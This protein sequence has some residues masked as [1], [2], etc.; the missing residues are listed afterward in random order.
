MNRIHE[1]FTQS[2]QILLMTSKHAQ[3]PAIN[4][5]ELGLQCAMFHFG[6]DAARLIVTDPLEVPGRPL[7]PKSV[8][9]V[10]P[11]KRIQIKCIQYR[12]L[13]SPAGSDETF[14]QDFF[15]PVDGY[16]FL[17]GWKIVHES[18]DGKPMFEVYSMNELMKT[19]VFN[20][21]EFGTQF[22]N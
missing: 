3:I 7:S 5:T 9:G 19:D 2:Y 20:D 1:L 12:I 14:V 6:F 22:I 15:H 21:D 16:C 18:P 8:L 11:K 17:D 13:A 10:V 4:F